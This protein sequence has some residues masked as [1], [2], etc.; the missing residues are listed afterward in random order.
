L[1]GISE[2]LLSKTTTL[3]G[4]CMVTELSLNEF[5]FDIKLMTKNGLNVETNSHRQATMI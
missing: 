5:Q 4:N 3:S 1:L 2:Y